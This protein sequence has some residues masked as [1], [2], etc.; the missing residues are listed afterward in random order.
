MESALED[1]GLKIGTRSFERIFR[2]LFGIP[3]NVA[4]GI[5]LRL[6]DVVPIYLLLALIFL[7][8]CNSVSSMSKTFGLDQKP[9]CK[10]V[11]F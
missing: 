3:Y 10:W 1:L 7:K 4:T 2:Y 8:N 9:V 6:A 11:D 5:S